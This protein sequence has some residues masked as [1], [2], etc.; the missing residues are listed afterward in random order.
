MQIIMSGL[1]IGCIYG[2]AALGLVLIY[3][4]TMVVNFAHGEMA[5]LSTFIGFSLMSSFKLNYFS[6]FIG[7]LLFSMILGVFLYN[8]FLKRVQHA[9]HLTQIVITLGIFLII[10]GLAGYI[11]GHQPVSFPTPFSDESFSVAGVLLSRNDLFIIFMTVTLM[12]ILYFIFRYTKIGLAM[13]ASAQDLTASRLMGVKVSFVF[14]STWAMGTLLGGV[15][16]LMTA[17]LTFLSP[18]MMFEI[19][20]MAFAA[21][22]LG[23][24]VSLPGVV[25]GGLLVGVFGNLIS[26]YLSSE[27]KVVYTFL[28]IIILLYIRPQ[29]IFG[30]KPTVKKV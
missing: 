15:A 16:G 19:L 18:T 21:A 12:G 1:I 4:T 17:P 29:G 14:M 28:L 7:A 11:W 13:R 26:Y 2:L 3:K 30:V 6:S 25:I 5:M 23:G 10:N 9:D 22:V 8:A 24:F 20:I 27:M